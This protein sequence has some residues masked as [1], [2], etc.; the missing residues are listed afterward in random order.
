MGESQQYRIRGP[1]VG[2]RQPPVRVRA[3]RAVKQRATGDMRLRNL[4]VQHAIAGTE[5]RLAAV[6]GGH[7]GLPESDRW[8]SDWPEDVRVPA[9]LIRDLV[10]GQLPECPRPRT[11]DLH[12]ARVVG[13]LMLTDAAVLCSLAFTDCELDA[14]YA[15][16]ARLPSLNLANCR[17]RQLMLRGA[18]VSSNVFLTRLVADLDHPND[19]LFAV[20]FSLADIGERM[21][22]YGGRFGRGSNGS[23]SASNARIGL[24]F[25]LRGDLQLDGDADLW[26]AKVEGAFGC[27]PTWGPNRERG[28]APTIDLTDADVR[29]LGGPPGDWEPGRYRL[30]G[31]TYASMGG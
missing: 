24:M 27:R 30:D 23:F 5:L 7:V 29:V 12:G 10:T 11:L 1:L 22:L 8:P 16:R 20:D 17:S 26:H 28:P 14:I 18:H 31:F 3:R 4:L 13:D 15:Y 9:D 25:A 21:I 2:S 6:A 19:A